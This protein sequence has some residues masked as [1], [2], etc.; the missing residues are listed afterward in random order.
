MQVS[1]S[2]EI[3]RLGMTVWLRVDICIQYKPELD[4]FQC[5]EPVQLMEEWSDVCLSIFDHHFVANLLLCAC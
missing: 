3:R 2:V 5:L 4:L 1:L